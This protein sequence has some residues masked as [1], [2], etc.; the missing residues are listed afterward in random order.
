[1]IFFKYDDEVDDVDDDD[2]DYDD[3]PLISYFIFLILFFTSSTDGVLPPRLLL[4]NDY[5]IS[6]HLVH[7]YTKWG[8][9][10]HKN[11]TYYVR[12]V[13]SSYYY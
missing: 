8:R 11:S 9:M 6:I 2:Y 1:M 13:A 7:Y 5:R 10:L 12:L 4:K 3:Y